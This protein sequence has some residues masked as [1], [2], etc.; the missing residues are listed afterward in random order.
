MYYGACFD[1]WAIAGTGFLT[2]VKAHLRVDHADEDVL[3]ASLVTAARIHLETML[4]LSFRYTKLDAGAG[5]VARWSR[6]RLAAWAGATDYQYQ[7][8]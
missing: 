4:G 2:E 8:I 6:C 1:K 3:L 5:Q 7:S